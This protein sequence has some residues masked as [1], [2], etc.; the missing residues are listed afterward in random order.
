VSRPAEDRTL[1]YLAGVVDTLK[2]DFPPGKRFAVLVYDERDPEATILVGAS[3]EEVEARLGLLRLDDHREEGRVSSE[4]G[5]TV[6]KGQSDD[7]R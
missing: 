7:E 6:N 1:R 4:G 3:I 2:A 5:T